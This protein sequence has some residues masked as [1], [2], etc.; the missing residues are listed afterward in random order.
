MG[1]NIENIG[2]MQIIKFKNS[3]LAYTYT[4]FTNRKFIFI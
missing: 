4:G 3:N 2:E 1:K